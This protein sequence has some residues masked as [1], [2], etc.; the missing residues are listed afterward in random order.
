MSE[1]HQPSLFPDLDAASVDADVP[2]S[3]PGATS[4][5]P[6]PTGD[7][8]DADARRLIAGDL[9]RTYFVEAGAGSGKSTAMVQ[10]VVSLI[11]AEPAA[12]DAHP[13]DHPAGPTTGSAASPIHRIAAITFTEKAALELRV[14]IRDALDTNTPSDGPGP[15]APPSAEA[16]ARRRAALLDLDS[17]PIGTIHSFCTNIL[18]RLPLEAGIPPRIEVEDASQSRLSFARMWRQARRS[19]LDEDHGEA[20]LALLDAGM[21]P[22]R[23]NEIAEGLHAAWDRT[24]QWLESST[25]RLPGR[26]RDAVRQ[27]RRQLQDLASAPVTAKNPSG[28]FAATT[29]DR[30]RTNLLV[31]DAVLAPDGSPNAPADGPA[32]GR[33]LH[34]VASLEELKPARTQIWGTEKGETKELCDAVNEAI[35]HA[36]AELVEELLDPVVRQVGRIV[37]DAAHERR[38]SGRLQFHDLL[39]LTRRLLVGEHREHAHRVLHQQLRWILVDEFQDTDPLQ[40]EILFRIAATAPSGTDDWRALTLRPGQ[41]FMV[42]DPKQSIYRF[43]GADISTYQSVEKALAA[44]P[45]GTGGEPTWS[46]ATLSTNFRSDPDVLDWVNTAFGELMVGVDLVQPEYEDLSVR[47]DAP[48]R[49]GEAGGASG[50]AI[51]RVLLDEDEEGTTGP[52]NVAETLATLIRDGQHPTTYQREAVAEPQRIRPQDVAIL[53]RARTVLPDLEDALDDRGIEYRT[54]AST[55]IYASTEVRELKLVLRAV[56]NLAD[57]GALVL[58]LRTSVLGCGDD[59]LATWRFAG[60]RWNIFGDVPEGLDAD[61]PDAQHPVARA[62]GE[63]RDLYERARRQTPAE[64][65]EHLVETHLVHAV[66]LDAPRHRDVSRRLT[67]VIDQARAWWEENHGSLREYLEWIDLEDTDDSSASETVLDEKDSSAVRI[68]TMHAAKGLEFP[69]VVLMTGK[70]PRSDKPS[71]LWD[72]DDVPRVHMGGVLT[73]A[74]YQEAHEHSAAML[75]AEMLRLMY[76]ACTRAQHLLVLPEYAEVRGDNA[77]ADFL[78]YVTEGAPDT[79]LPP[80]APA[81]AGALSP[82]AASSVAASPAAPSTSTDP[83]HEPAPTTAPAWLADWEA[84]RERWQARSAL[85][86]TTSVTALAHGGGRGDR[87]AE[88]VVTAPGRTDPAAV[89]TESAEAALME[90]N[91]A[92]TGATPEE[93]PAG[94]AQPIGGDSAGQDADVP[95]LIVA[96]TVFG[97][98]LHRTLELTRLE[99]SADVEAIAQQVAEQFAPGSSTD[100]AT[101]ITSGADP[102]SAPTGLDVGRLTAMARFALSTEVMAEAARTGRHWFELDMNAPADPGSADRD[103]ADAGPNDAAADAPAILVGRADFVFVGEDGRLSVVDFKSDV[104]PSPGRVEEYR[105]QVRAYVDVLSRISGLPAGRGHL[106]FAAPEQARVLTVG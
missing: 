77:L 64:L 5:S 22:N 41:L 10:R 28:K 85:P 43:R 71:L 16:R 3:S 37:V 72:A 4:G 2:G 56:A 55:L 23:L 38:R 91:A 100:P 40:A 103:S 88:A 96:G 53:L 44:Q 57:T 52:E 34:A 101:R 75:D 50:P 17:A 36:R 94:R 89:E 32:V 12:A 73:G 45:L 63:L 8:V 39:V 35:G 60:G 97:N 74:G 13:A 25:P 7:L 90:A 69:V 46:R 14:K 62:L 20:I 15:G 54:E 58:A 59:D 9:E 61:G 102:T 27:V 49:R 18:R 106:L 1:Q 31:L 80:P 104:D 84:K 99:A 79:E 67:Y 51:R 93:P 87:A 19:V 29:L 86:A 81:G 70:H 30:V 42:G 47:P 98:A 92:E 78:R 21:G 11:D 83:Q 76:V 24:E 6:A 65:L 82:A 26:A 68:L 105:S 95:Q 48:A 33:L 66:V